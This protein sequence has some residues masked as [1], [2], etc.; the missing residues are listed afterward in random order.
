MQKKGYS[1]SA[2]LAPLLREVISETL[3]AKVKDPRVEAVVVTSIDVAS[4]LGSA[5][6]GY[7]LMTEAS[8]EEAQKGL[9]SVVGFLRKAISDQLKLRY[10][11]RLKFV[12]DRG[13]DQGRRIDAILRDI[14]GEAD[15]AGP[16][17][18]GEPE[19]G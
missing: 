13:V 17:E 16:D 5:R 15:A 2:R 3:Q 4:D 6:I 11:P 7:Y 18:P 1:R 12:F 19:D 8:V 10:A 14:H 9:D